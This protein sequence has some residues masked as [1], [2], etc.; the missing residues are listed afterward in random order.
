M[1]REDVN[2]W[3]AAYIDAWKSYD[4]DR[5]GALFSEDAEYRYY[6][7]REPLRGREAIVAS[8]LAI[9]DVEGDVVRYA[10][11]RKLEAAFAAQNA[12]DK[13]SQAGRR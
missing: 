5:I 6:P 13:T 11:L 9:R 12:A 4:R 8:W 2:R 3:L 7:G 1:N 10:S